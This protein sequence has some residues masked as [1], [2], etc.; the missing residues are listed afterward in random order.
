[1]TQVNHLLEKFSLD[2]KI[3][4][5]MLEG[6]ALEIAEEAQ[7]DI[8]QLELE[9]QLSQ[10]ECEEMNESNWDIEQEL[11]DTQKLY[12]NLVNEIEYILNSKKIK[13]TEILTALKEAL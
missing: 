13:K 10:E 8:D 12:K 4:Y 2:E 6:Q 1:M 7:Y 11:R 3:R 5:S 9:L